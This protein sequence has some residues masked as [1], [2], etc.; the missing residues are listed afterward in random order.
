MRIAWSSLPLVAGLL[1]CSHEA[2]PND[3]G[4]TGL[5]D[6][7]DTGSGGNASDTGDSGDAG[8]SGDPGDYGSPGDLVTGQLT[9]SDWGGGGSLGTWG[10]HGEIVPCP[11]C[12]YAFDATFTG[13]STFEAT[14]RI[15]DFDGTWSIVLLEYYGYAYPL[16][17]GLEDPPGVT[18]FDNE[19]LRE[20]LG[21][22]AGYYHYSGYFD[23]P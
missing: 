18:T 12:L 14:I 20:K 16:G 8:D 3:K 9:V 1:A 11:D 21:Y 2:T 10:V 17:L 5:F 22:D 13:A 19:L 7:G 15:E 6:L 23:H 4:S